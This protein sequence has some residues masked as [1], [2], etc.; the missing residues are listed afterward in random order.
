MQRSKTTTTDFNKQYLLL[1]QHRAAL[2]QTEWSPIEPITD[3]QS[4]HEDT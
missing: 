2:N 3:S 1:R 4:Q